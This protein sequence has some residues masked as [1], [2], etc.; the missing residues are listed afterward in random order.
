M[1]PP[2]AKP[3]FVNFHLQMRGL[4]AIERS[5]IAGFRVPDPTAVW[6]NIVL[7][8]GAEVSLNG[9]DLETAA[10]ILHKF[11]DEATSG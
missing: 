7:D 5:R 3:L 4:V 8:T 9:M 1:N 11:D 2:S 6:T 10:D